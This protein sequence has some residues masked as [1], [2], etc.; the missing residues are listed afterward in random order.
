VV[1]NAI[2]HGLEKP[3]ERVNAGKSPRPKFSARLRAADAGLA[4]ELADD[5]RG[6]DWEQV[7][8]LAEERG[9]PRETRA[10]LVRALLGS[11]FSTRATVTATSGRG[12]GLDA[13]AHEV[14]RLGGVIDVVSDPG[15]GTR[16][17]IRLPM[18]LVSLKI[19][20]TRA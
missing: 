9:L 20:G 8:V 18:P 6:I 7:K 3:D 19:A 14:H 17:S 11:G 4:I 1:R 2:D 10:D 15:Q 13:V 5:G 12:V 16:W